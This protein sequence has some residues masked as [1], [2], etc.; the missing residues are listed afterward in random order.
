[1]STNN[2]KTTQSTKYLT[3]EDYWSLYNF[4]LRRELENEIIIRFEKKI[5]VWEDKFYSSLNRYLEK[6]T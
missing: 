5:N 4:M 1:M 3:P 2:L 6:M